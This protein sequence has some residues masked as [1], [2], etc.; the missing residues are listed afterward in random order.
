[1]TVMVLGGAGYIG[2]VTVERLVET[3]RKVVVYDNLS[4]GH[5]EAVEANV[6]F[7]QGDIA[8]TQLL[9]KTIR[10]RKVKSVMH[11]CAHSLVGESVKEPLMYYQNNLRNGI[12]L[13][14][15]LRRCE[16]QQFIFSST[17][18]TFGQPDTE[19]ITETT[20]QAPTNPYGRSK[21][22]FEKILQ[23]CSEAYGFRSV[24]LRYFNACGA[25]QKHG[26]D[27]SP[28]THLIPVVLDVALGKRE[29]LGVFGRDYATPD[30]TCVRDYIH[31]SD[32]ADAHILA[33]ESLEKG[34]KT[35]SYNLGNGQ[36]FSVLDV[37][38]AVEE[39]TCK[40]IP[41]IDSPR[42]PGDPARLVA[43][44]DR[45]REELHWHPKFTD[46]KQIIRTAW[47]WKL[48]HLT[49]YGQLED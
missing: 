28:E 3:G 39:V 38:R 20:A 30:G 45:I 1:M 46:L 5:A 25:T 43:S 41:T 44:S 22:M 36:G 35:T 31:V 47:D 29:A 21:L 11:F 10:E 4:R 12:D 34:G 16:V 27:H 15:T 17:A 40:H 48:A 2:S 24:A 14:E 32:L 37:V 23:D 42:R 8:D 26:E 13:I 6:P 33:L 7:V 19:F 49:G 9:E 18:A